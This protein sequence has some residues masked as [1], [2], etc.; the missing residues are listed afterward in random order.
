[1]VTV[2]LHLADLTD[3][4]SKILCDLKTNFDNGSFIIQERICGIEK[5][6]SDLHNDM[7]C[8]KQRMSKLNPD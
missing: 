7:E 5:I 2:L 8:I 6:I 4:W 3:F 1:M